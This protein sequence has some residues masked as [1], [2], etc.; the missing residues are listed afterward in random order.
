[1]RLVDKLIC[2]GILYTIFFDI[3]PN[4]LYFILD[5]Y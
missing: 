2:I 1:M 5:M 4:I 3:S